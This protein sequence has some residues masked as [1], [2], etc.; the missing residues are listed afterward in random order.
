[1][2]K[3]SINALCLTSTNLNKGICRKNST[4]DAQRIFFHQ[5]LDVKDTGKA[6]RFLQLNNDINT[7]NRHFAMII[8][9]EI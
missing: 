9:S 2:P 6:W 8:A 7:L 3:A 4:R 5:T 1:M